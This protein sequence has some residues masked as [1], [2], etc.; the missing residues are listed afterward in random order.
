MPKNHFDTETP[1]T[2]RVVP[3]GFPVISGHSCTNSPV[4]RVSVDSFGRLALSLSK[5]W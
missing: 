1:N 5:G 2:K 3:L 4:L